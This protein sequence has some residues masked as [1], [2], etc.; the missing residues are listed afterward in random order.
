MM[1]KFIIS[2]KSNKTYSLPD[3]IHI[4][5]LAECSKDL[6]SQLKEKKPRYFSKHVKIKS[7]L[8]QEKNSTTTSYFCHLETSYE[9][10]LMHDEVIE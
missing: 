5:L 4:D 10:L 3:I 1:N 2:T 6:Q 7:S 8:A 9:P